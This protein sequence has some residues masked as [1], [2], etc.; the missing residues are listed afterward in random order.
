MESQIQKKGSSKSSS[1]PPLNS[2]ANNSHVP[3]I[4]TSTFTTQRK[5]Q[6]LADNSSQVQNIAQLKPN[7]TGLPD[8]LKTGIESLS[9]YSMDDVKVHYN[10]SKP[11]QLNA[12]AYAQGTDI[13]LASGQ[14]KHLPHEA[15]H[16]VQQKQ[17]RVK[18]TMQMKD[19]VNINDDAGLE[20]EADVMGEKALQK[21][22]SIIDKSYT[23]ITT[24]RSTTQLKSL[25][26]ANKDSNI[27]DIGNKHINNAQD[28][29]SVGRLYEMDSE[30]KDTKP[31]ALVEAATKAGIIGARVEDET[32]MSKQKVATEVK[33]LL[34]QK[35]AAVNSRLKSEKNTNV[36][37]AVNFIDMDKEMENI[38]VP[39]RY[40]RFIWTNIYEGTEET[41]D[42][43]PRG[44]LVTLYG[45]KM[46]NNYE[47]YIN[48]RLYF[49]VESNLLSHERNL[50]FLDP[51]TLRVLSK[52]GDNDGKMELDYQFAHDWPGYVVNIKHT[53]GEGA[54]F[55]S[56]MSLEHIGGGLG[57]PETYSNVHDTSVDETISGQ[58]N[59]D[60]N[61]SKSTN[62]KKIDAHARIAGEGP[63]WVA[64]RQH[65]ANLKNSSLFYVEQP[66]QDAVLDT[67]ERDVFYV[68]FN[69]LWLSWEPVFSKKYNISNATFAQKLLSPDN[70][71][72]DGRKSDKKRKDMGISDKHVG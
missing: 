8:N 44:P 46:A 26:Q 17:G 20:K 9:G 14:E 28:G 39:Q 58:L 54:A 23:E 64:V 51:F 36:N 38:G 41:K 25:H 24:N 22:C 37:A 7:N 4:E 47:T 72:G 62:E 45:A 19:K 13:H 1:K 60:S 56:S 67:R 3:K 15:W 66:N 55:D 57:I 35:K 42:F 50:K 65:V 10:S 29:P 16:V 53:G 31:A 69:T 61:D 12:H 49:M 68:S 6:D 52:Y 2:W 27:N 21:K 43:R 34:N 18:P 71:G 32:F 59:L 63:R 40:A 33:S 48:D 70:W 11:A 5:L 30:E